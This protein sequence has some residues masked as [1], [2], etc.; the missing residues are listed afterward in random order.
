MFQV[1]SR[2]LAGALGRDG[3]SRLGG[4]VV[5]QR[6]DLVCSVVVV[7][8]AWL[9][10]RRHVSSLSAVSVADASRTFQRAFAVCVQPGR[11]GSRSRVAVAAGES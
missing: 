3:S 11:C 8:E 5:T 7:C 9:W 10:E 6:R 4:D 2:S 1:A